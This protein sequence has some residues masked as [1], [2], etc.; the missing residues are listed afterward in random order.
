MISVSIIPAK[1]RQTISSRRSRSYILSP[2]TGLDPYIAVSPL[3]GTTTRAFVTSPC[4]HKS[5]KPSTIFSTQRP[6]APKTPLMPGT[7]LSMALP[8]DMLTSPTIPPCCLPSS[9]T[10]CS[11]SSA[12]YYT[13]T[14]LLTLP[15]L[16]PS[17][18]LLSRNKKQ[19]KQY[20]TQ[21][22]GSSIML[23]P[24]QMQPSDKVPVTLSYT[25]TVT[26]P[27][28]PNPALAAASVATISLAKNP[29]TLPSHLSRT[30]LPTALSIP[31]PISSTT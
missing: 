3:T 7:N 10:F 12:L 21:Q 13:T 6:I 24:T 30:P 17:V 29:L 2:S 9:S 20:V 28:F 1:T 19:R 8:S 26:P 23:C 25:S 11:R 5:M 15:C 4:P 18:P 16:F 22:I 14:S 31:S 27:T